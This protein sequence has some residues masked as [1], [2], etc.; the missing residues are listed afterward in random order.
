MYQGGKHW[1]LKGAVFHPQSRFDTHP[2]WLSVTQS[3]RSWQIYRKIG[4]CEQ[5]MIQPTQIPIKP[6]YW[7]NQYCNDPLLT[8]VSLQYH[9][10]IIVI[11]KKFLTTQFLLTNPTNQLVNNFFW[12]FHFLVNLVTYFTT[13]WPIACKAFF[14]IMLAL[15]TFQS[16]VYKFLL[17]TI[18]WWA[19]K[20]LNAILA[21]IRFYPILCI[22]IPFAICWLVKAHTCITKLALTRFYSCTCMYKLMPLA[23]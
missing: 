17:L 18:I 9:M 21:L 23:N 4:D 7:K 3:V 6:T 2:R 20:E 12:R 15:I 10:L 5:T 8:Q 22:I 11:Q 16:C 19:V 14:T 1:G 13:W